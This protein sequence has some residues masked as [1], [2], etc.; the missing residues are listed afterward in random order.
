VN[1]TSTCKIALLTKANLSQLVYTH[2][3]KPALPR[4]VVGS[5]QP[6]E[7]VMDYIT[8]GEEHMEM[9]P[10]SPP[11][12]W[13]APQTMSRSLYSRSSPFHA[14]DVLLIFVG[15]ALPILH[16]PKA[17]GEGGGHLPAKEA[18]GSAVTTLSFAS[19]RAHRR[20]SVEGCPS[21]MGRSRLRR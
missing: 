1:R 10:P 6:L 5:A 2:Q 7:A 11:Q 20:L 16:R 19:Q 13:W 17:Q 3:Q 15:D 18:L 21:A 14:E 8:A 9:A 12:A 4:L